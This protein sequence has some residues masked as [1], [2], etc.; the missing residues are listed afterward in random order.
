MLSMTLG[1]LALLWSGGP[2]LAIPPPKLQLQMASHDVRFQDYCL[3]S[4]L[5]VVFQEDLSQPVV[6]V[7]TV[8]GSGASSDPEGMEGMAHLVEHLWFRSAQLHVP[9]VWQLR[10]RLGAWMNGF[11]SFDTTKYTTVAPARYVRTLLEIEGQRLTNTLNGV[12]EDIFLTEREVVRN[13]LRQNYENTGRSGMS[14][15]YLRLFPEGHPYHRTVIGD[16][17]SLDTIDLEAANAFAAQHYQ[18]TNT[19]IM[20]VGDIDLDATGAWLAQSFPPALL[21]GP[22]SQCEARLPEEPP[23]VPEP[24]DTS[25]VREQAEVDAIQA[26][27][28]WAVP[29]G[30]RPVEGLER[31]VMGMLDWSLERHQSRDP[32]CSI[33]VQTEASIISCRLD[34]RPPEDPRAIQDPEQRLRRALDGVHELWDMNNRDWQA[35]SYN[36]TRLAQAA[37][38]FLSGEE[39]SGTYSTR[40]TRMTENLHHVGTVDYFIPRLQWLEPIRAGHAAEFAARYLDKRRAV[41]TILDPFED[42]SLEAGWHK[43]QQGGQELEEPLPTDVTVAE[44]VERLLVPLDLEPLQDFELD[45][46]LRVLMLPFGTMPYTRV[47]LLFPGGELHETQPELERLTWHA[48]TTLWQDEQGLTMTRAPNAIGGRWSLESGQG[49]HEY[50]ISGSGGNLEAQLYLLRRRMDSLRVKFSEKGDYID[51]L[52]RSIW[53]QRERPEHWAGELSWTILA[54]DHPSTRPLDEATLDAAREL[55]LGDMKAWSR[56]IVTPEN[57]TLVVVGRYDEERARDW[58]ERWF[59]DWDPRGD[60]VPL[61][62]PAPLP[63]PPDRRVIVVDKPTATQTQVTLRCQMKGLDAERVMAQS[64]AAELLAG[65]S[66]YELRIRSGATYGVHRSFRDL[67]G[68]GRLLTLSTD[69]Q[70]SAAGE[71][72]TTILDMVQ[73]IGSGQLSTQPLERTQLARAS[74]YAQGQQTTGQVLNRL[75]W[76]LERGMDLDYVTQYAQR[77]GALEPADLGAVLY[78]CMGHEVITLVGPRADIV[79][80]LEAAEVPHEV[81]DWQAERDRMMQEHAPDR[82]K[83][84]LKRREKEG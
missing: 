34:L 29:G 10:T 11:T 5:R 28:T 77:L 66:K 67:P 84:E 38:L 20:V 44:E 40:S 31:M 2:A 50:A 81:F 14:S 55:G 48:T 62:A 43:H 59:G 39:V 23:A 65:R 37:D 6:S 71:T 25:F 45:T 13:E 33:Y 68:T 63:A 53:R 74:A 83:D 46:G 3:P 49:W 64:L 72:V 69:V 12:D 27:I 36:R 18:P 17:L 47:G 24:T 35:R 16:H 7:S 8:V 56:R 9:A 32:D 4:G 70:N 52:E 41:V 54:P 21:E 78:R 15:S 26:L 75:L 51:G 22:G 42:R 80:Q 79:S 73:T 61:P 76:P 58:V 60:P 82:W 19:T 57:A 1:L 30:Y